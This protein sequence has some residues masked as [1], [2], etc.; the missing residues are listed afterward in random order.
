MMKADYNIISKEYDSSPIRKKQP[1]PLFI[2][3][4]RS[5]PLD[6]PVRVID[7]GC[8]TGTWI[9]I[10]QDAVQNKNIE[11][12][13]LEPSRSML[14]KAHRKLNDAILICAK[15]EEIPFEDNF[16]H[17]DCTEYAFHQFEDKKKAAQSDIA[18]EESKTAKLEL[19][20]K[21]SDYDLIIS[22][23]NDAL[24]RVWLHNR[25]DRKWFWGFDLL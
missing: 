1:D 4:V 22:E 13:G 2:E 7:I 16:F 17:Y 11:W 12:Y 24:G 10:N 15:A 25:N 8:G 3:F 14:D 20:E 19:G 9:A 18:K 6:F 5:Q 23:A 21:I